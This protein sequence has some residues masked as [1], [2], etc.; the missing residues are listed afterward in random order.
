MGPWVCSW[1]GAWV[2]P[3][4]CRTMCEGVGSTVGA[5]TGPCG[6]RQTAPS[7]AL[8]VGWPL[9][10]H[11]HSE[12]LP[13]G[14]SREHHGVVA[15]P[16]PVGRPLVYHP[17]P[18]RLHLVH[19]GVATAPGA[20]DHMGGAPLPALHPLGSHGGRV[21]GGGRVQGV[22]VVLLVHDHW[23]HA[24]GGLGAEVHHLSSLTPSLLV[25]VALEIGPALPTT[26][27]EETTHVC[28][29]DTHTCVYV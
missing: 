11:P 5:A 15:A 24:E 12:R 4:V 17:H 6:R 21:S 26:G 23:V 10:Y 3:W 22:V 28:R 13:M 18:V 1:V 16:G 29:C 25:L 20:T 9:V 14:G 19:H 8:P 2:G 27:G 7:G